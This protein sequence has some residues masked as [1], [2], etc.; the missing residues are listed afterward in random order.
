MNPEDDITRPLPHAVGPE[1]SILSSM[2][3][4]PQEFIPAAIE[5]G[6]SAET[7]YL[8]AHRTLFTALLNLH[9][10]GQPLELVGLVQHLLDNGK[11]EACGGAS[12]VYEL[13]TYA[14]SPG[15]FHYHLGMVKEKFTLRSMIAAANAIVQD[16][17]DSPE[18]VSASLDAAE[19]A[20]LAIRDHS[21]TNATNGVRDAISDVISE[22]QKQIAGEKPILG[23]ETGYPDLDRKTSGLKP[24]ELIII[25]ARPSVGKSALMMNIVEHVVLNQE[26][27]AAV[28]SCEMSTQALMKRSI[29]GTARFAW[30]TLNEGHNPNKGELQRIQSAAMRLSKAPLYIDDTPGITITALRAKARRL[31]RSHGIQ[32]IAVDYLQLLKSSSRQADN[33]REREVAEISAGLKALAKELHLPVIVLAQ[34]NRDSEKRTGK[35]KGRPKM[36]DLRESGAIEQDADI[37]GLLSREAYSADTQD[38]RDN[39]AGAACL[40]IAKNRTGATGSVYLTFI[41]EIVRFEPGSKPEHQES[42]S[43]QPDF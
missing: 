4:D 7:L 41:P 6:F 35:G 21:A 38:D 11:L 22:M 37:I 16:A 24:G 32:L 8:P 23:I 28:F 25:A 40:D 19:R 13:Y 10:A 29:G 20:I 42:K 36:S 30:Q 15:H 43:R 1:K 33:S 12:S 3:Q 39:A 18:A 2:L 5:T 31:H 14:A 27:P 9:E 26:L 17:Y 34:L